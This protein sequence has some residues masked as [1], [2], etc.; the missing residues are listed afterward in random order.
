MIPL[1]DERG[2]YLFLSSPNSSRTPRPIQEALDKCDLVVDVSTDLA[3]PRAIAGRGTVKRAISAFIT[4]SGLGAV[5]LVEDDRRTVRLDALEAQYYRHVISELWGAAH[6]ASNLREVWTGAGCRD[7]SVVIPGELIALP[8]GKLGAHDANPPRPPRGR[9]AGLAPRSRQRGAH[10][11]QLRPG[12]AGSFGV[13][14]FP[15][16]LG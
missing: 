2:T 11:P 4:P 7:L 8:C 16:A 14:L 3:V 12:G 15:G 10:K 1:R 9:V 13:G 6:L 5:M